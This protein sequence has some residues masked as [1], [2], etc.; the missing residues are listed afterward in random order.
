VK[1]Q[2]NQTHIFDSYKETKWHYLRGGML[3]PAPPEVDAR[4]TSG[5]TVK[6]DQTSIWK[7][8]SAET[9]FT[10]T[11]H[12]PIICVTLLGENN[13]RRSL[14]LQPWPEGSQWWLHWMPEQEYRM[15]NSKG[16]R[17]ACPCLSPFCENSQWSDDS[18]RGTVRRGANQS[19]LPEGKTCSRTEAGGSPARTGGGKR[20]FTRLV[21]YIWT[22]HSDV[23]R[24]DFLTAER[25]PTISAGFKGEPY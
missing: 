19:S 8:I 22:P 18:L 23:W 7:T 16:K 12:A 10:C 9:N 11:N 14:R 1:Q 4:Q 6:H 13:W 21:S 15:Q 3:V 5:F 20:H 25:H 24:H 2:N 17:G